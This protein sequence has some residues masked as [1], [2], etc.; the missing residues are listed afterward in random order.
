MNRHIERKNH[1]QHLIGLAARV[2]FLAMVFYT[3]RSSA[4]PWSFGVM[5]DTQWKG[6]VDGR[7]TV[8]TGIINRINAEF[9]AAKVK[10]VIQVGDL[11]DKYPSKTRNSMDT[12]AEAAQVLY[13]A[14]IGFFPLRGNHEKSPEAAAR[15][16]Q[17]FPQT[18][19][20]INTFGAANFS[21]PGKAN[22]LSYAFDYENARFMLLDQFAATMEEQQSWINPVIR[23]KPAGGHAFVFAHKGIIT[24]NHLDTLFGKDPSKNPAAQNL[25]MKSMHDAGIRYFFGGHDHMHNRAIVA[26]P[27]GLFQVHE[28]ICAGNS[29]KFYGPAVPCPDQKVNNPARETPISQELNAFGYYIVTVSGP[30]V[31]VDYYSSAMVAD[32]NPPAGG[33]ITISALPARLKFVKKESFG[34]SLNGRQ[35]LVGPGQS[36][37]VV[38][39]TFGNTSAKII[40]G[41][42]GCVLK[43]GSGR[44]LTR[45]ITT[46]WTA[47]SES[48]DKQTLKSDIFI[49]WGMTDLGADHTE[50]FVLQMSYDPKDIAGEQ[51]IS[52][53]F[54]LYANVAGKWTLAVDTNIGGKKCFVGDRP[55][56]TAGWDTLGMYGYDGSNHTVWAV[57]DYNRAFAAR[58]GQAGQ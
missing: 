45:E 14:G 56:V 46:G 18:Q 55:P 40:S 27:N 5:G 54:G 53:S 31:T 37:S 34:Y 58:V 2:L 7:D 41:V 20:T 17:D 19:G 9:I 47:Q 21:S 52:G 13:G 36:Y 48:A 23:T 8:A 3:A 49:I 15:F 38:A 28:I 51:L 42:N 29:H 1:L 30:L 32:S 10:F 6:K 16:V 39:D 33:E 26:S 25:F 44:S 35:F 4:E 57:I 12:R 22:G 11:V 24:E 50:P 43:D